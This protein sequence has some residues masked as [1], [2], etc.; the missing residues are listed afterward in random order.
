[1]SDLF[2]FDRTPCPDYW[3]GSDRL[4]WNEGKQVC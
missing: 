3:S 4:V 1:M 2:R